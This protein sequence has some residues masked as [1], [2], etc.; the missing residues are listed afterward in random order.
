MIAASAAAPWRSRLIEPDEA[1][2][3]KNVQASVAGATKE[4]VSAHPPADAAA[5]DSQPRRTWLDRS[6]GA[7]PV[8]AAGLPRLR[9][10]AIS[11][12]RS[13]SRL[14]VA[15]P[16][17][18]AAGRPRR[19]SRGND[20]AHRAGTLFPRAVAVADR[21]RPPGGRRQCRWLCTRK[22]ERGA[23]TRSR[24]RS[25]RSRRAGGARGNARRGE[26]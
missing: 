21:P 2:K 14:F 26:A 24:R 1:G 4:S 16:D 20:L 8:R 15:A 22:R 17:L 9:L 23:V 11:A 7:R 12:A 3:A 13:L 10:R 25:A 5:G 19:A 6:S 18:A